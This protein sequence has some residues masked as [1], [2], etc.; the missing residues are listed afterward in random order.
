[1]SHQRREVFA[2]NWKMYKNGADAEKYIKEMRV[3]AKKNTQE[4][5]IF[6]PSIYLERAIAAAKGS[7]IGVGVQNV[8]WEHEGAYTGD[9]SASMAAEAGC[10][11][12]LCGHSERRHYY[13]ESAEM[14]TRKTHSALTKELIPVICVGE[15]LMERENGDT[16]EVLYNDTKAAISGIEP[17]DKIIIAYEPVWAIGT[18]LSAT[19][20]DAQ[21]AI[22]YIRNVVRELWGDIADR[23]RIIYGGS[24]NPGNI[25]ELM[26]C[27]DIDGALVGGASLDLNKFMSIINYQQ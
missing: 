14:V 3:L 10:D 22:A 15:T 23:I 2:A 13:S 20:K 4:L 18:G 21:T 16:L 19:P 11:Y 6:P 9:I 5:I 25:A 27:Q 17:N 24:V 8:H 7:N 1:M 12:C 26:A